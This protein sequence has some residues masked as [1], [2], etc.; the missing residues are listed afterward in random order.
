MSNELK[1]PGPARGPDDEIGQLLQPLYQAPP[2]GPYWDDLHSRIM[3]RVF[4]SGADEWW[5][6]LSRWA[7]VGAAAAVIVAI[8]AGALL[9]QFE[10]R[11]ARLAQERVLNEPAYSLDMSTEGLNTDPDAP[12]ANPI[13]RYG[14]P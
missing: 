9:M 4:N 11:D 8:L 3:H 7:R 5:L 2:D 13:L 10:S 1:F 12:L 6:V 14:L